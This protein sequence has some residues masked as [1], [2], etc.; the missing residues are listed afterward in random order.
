MITAFIKYY[1]MLFARDRR[2]GWGNVFL[3][4]LFFK[5]ITPST[6]NI[7]C[8]I[9]LRNQSP[10]CSFNLGATKMSYPWV[11]N[12]LLGFAERIFLILRSVSWNLPRQLNIGWFFSRWAPVW[13]L[14]YEWG[15]NCSCKTDTRSRVVLCS[16]YVISMTLWLHVIA[17][18]SHLVN[19]YYEV[20]TKIE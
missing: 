3:K 17:N 7:L 13:L 5:L 15:N 8:S 16:W 6:I 14:P 1:W 2:V 18:K 19:S 12:Q 9:I 4:F 11:S 20:I 10:S